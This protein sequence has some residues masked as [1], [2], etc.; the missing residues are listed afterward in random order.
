MPGA[1]IPRAPLDIAI[2][3][4]L[5]SSHISSLSTAPDEHRLLGRIRDDAI[6]VLPMIVLVTIALALLYLR[7]RLFLPL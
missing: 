5:D 7:I 4:S 6:A 2:M 1:A 3:T